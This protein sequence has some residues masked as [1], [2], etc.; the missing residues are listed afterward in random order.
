MI[1]ATYLHLSCSSP[2]CSLQSSHTGLLQPLPGLPFSPSST[3]CLKMDPLQSKRV[4]IKRELEPY[5]TLYLQ[6]A[7]SLQTPFASIQCELSFVIYIAKGPKWL[8]LPPPLWAPR[9]EASALFF[10]I[11]SV[12]WRRSGIGHSS[13]YCTMDLSSGD[14]VVGKGTGR[15]RGRQRAKETLCLL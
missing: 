14:C 9:I 8:S 5:I 1:C 6:L 4:E 7:V 13:I 12:S 11:S 3:Y 10:S 2:P 15:S